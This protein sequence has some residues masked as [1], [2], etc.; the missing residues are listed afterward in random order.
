MP[1]LDGSFLVNGAWECGGID[2]KKV[3]WIIPPYEME[4]RINCCS[5]KE[6]GAKREEGIS[7]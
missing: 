3:K 5:D 2:L 4:W 1:Q 6:L 7:L